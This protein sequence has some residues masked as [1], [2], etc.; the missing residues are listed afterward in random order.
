MTRGEIWANMGEW[1]DGKMRFRCNAMLFV[2][3]IDAGQP[4]LRLRAVGFCSGGM[5]EVFCSPYTKTAKWGRG[6]RGRS[7][8]GDDPG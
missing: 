7:E 2:G 8:E 5:N 6:R 4:M 1:V 3:V